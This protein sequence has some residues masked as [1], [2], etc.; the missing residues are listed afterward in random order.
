MGGRGVGF[1]CCGEIHGRAKHAAKGGSAL[2][3]ASGLPS[4]PSQ[5]STAHSVVGGFVGARG[6]GVF[7]CGEIHE[8]AKH[9]ARGASALLAAPGLPNSPSQTSTAHPI[10]AGFLGA[11][12]AGVFCCGEIHEAAWRNTWNTQRGPAWRAP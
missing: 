11:R 5:T 10:V 9:A 12:G 2:L 3:A 6:A 1:F 7:C 4:S 8:E